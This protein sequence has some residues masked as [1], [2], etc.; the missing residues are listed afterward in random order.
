MTMQIVLITTRIDLHD[1]AR[2]DVCYNP[3]GECK[4]VHF[5]NSNGLRFDLRLRLLR[6]AREYERGVSFLYP[7][8]SFK[9]LKVAPHALRYN[10]LL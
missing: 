4:T 8:V 1:D 5:Q 6:V 2:D 9:D 10:A 7:L 3:R